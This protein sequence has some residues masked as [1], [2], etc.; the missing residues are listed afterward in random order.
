MKYMVL[1]KF[2]TVDPEYGEVARE[3]LVAI[4]NE[5]G[6]T[7]ATWPTREAVEYW[8]SHSSRAALPHQIVEVTI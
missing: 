1:I 6:F 7:V 4:E 3:Q 5:D 2:L 8:L